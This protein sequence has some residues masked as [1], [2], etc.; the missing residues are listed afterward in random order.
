M[1]PATAKDTPH[2]RRLV[3]TYEDTHAVI[4]VGEKSRRLDEKLFVV[5]EHRMRPTSGRMFA[6]RL[7][8]FFTLDGTKAWLRGMGLIGDDD[9][10]MKGVAVEFKINRKGPKDAGDL[11]DHKT[12]PDLGD[13]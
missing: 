13:D 4:G 7:G 1:T 8:V 2:N 6:K 10:P 12:G 3:V 9:Q 11:D 5:T